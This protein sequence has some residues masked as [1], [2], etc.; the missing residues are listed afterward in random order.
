MDTAKEPS[1]LNKL[2]NRETLP[3]LTSKDREAMTILIVDPEP[4]TRSI[5]R[6]LLNALGVKSV[7]DCADNII[8]LQKLEQRF[9]SHIIFDARHNKMPSSEFLG[10]L[11]EYAKPIIAIP[12]SY[13]PSVDDVFDLLIMG[14][15]GFLVKPCNEQSLEDALIMATK[16]DPISDSILYAKDR[17]EALVALIMTNVDRLATIM[18]QSRQFETAKREIAKATLALKRSVEI[19]RHFAKGGEE[20]LLEKI[21]EYAI[22]RGSGPATKLGR[23]RQKRQIK[24]GGALKSKEGASSGD[25]IESDATTAVSSN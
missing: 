16:A 18:R 25:L 13:A 3:K 23:A 1:F 2:F 21:L 20:K 11:L 22:E 14:A 15:R 8:A 19:G 6:Q 17:N 9:F 12:S 4:S 10:H 7:S 5:Q 24:K